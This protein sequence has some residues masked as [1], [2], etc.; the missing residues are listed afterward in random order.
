MLT[1]FLRP[2]DQLS[3][4]SQFEDARDKK[5]CGLL[6][7]EAFQVKCK[8]ETLDDANV[9]GGRFVLSIKDLE[10]YAP[11]FKECF[12]V[13]HHTDMEKNM[14]KNSATNGKQVAVRML[15]AM[16]TIFGYRI[17]TQDFAPTRRIVRTSQVTVRVK[18][19]G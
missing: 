14:L 13:P 9:L 4:Y 10:S 12:V 19:R 11:L 8:E 18:R 15:V 17:W 5:L 1:E 16:A 2:A 3:E 6:R 7:R